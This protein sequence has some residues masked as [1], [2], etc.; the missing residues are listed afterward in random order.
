MKKIRSLSREL[1]EEGFVLT[2]LEDEYGVELDLFDNGEYLTLDKL[3]IP[4]EKRNSG[5]GSKIMDYI[6]SYSDTKGKPIYLTPTKNFGATSMPRLVNFY[7]KH[8]FKNKPKSDFT[9]RNTL[10]R[11]PKSKRD[12][13]EGLIENRIEEDYPKD[14]DITQFKKINSYA[15]K[16]RYAKEYLG[17]PIGTGSSR[18][19]YRVDDNKVLKLAKNRKGI[20]QNRAET[21]W[22]G[23]HYFSDVLAQVIDY[24]KED[25]LWVEMELAVR[26]K[27]RD[28]KKLWEIDFLELGIYLSI[29][30]SEINGKRSNYRMSEEE[31]HPYAE[32]AEVQKLTEF[33][34]TS[35]SS[36]GDLGR[37]SSW[38]KVKR[39]GEED[40]VLVDF[41][42]TS[43][44]Y[45]SYYS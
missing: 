41:G 26:A 1:I 20:V 42:L 28:F 39:D 38:G 27:K 14:F 5:L 17:K 8:G 40:L 2:N 21:D 3:I 23:D 9:S 25:D 22:A 24:D 11:A 15:G 19:V 18:V 30:D 43:D 36:P 7:K 33:M 35:D 37:I 13:F 45:N 12:M 29:R 44:V 6:V 16:L 4:K 34:T 31:R 32:S 10:V